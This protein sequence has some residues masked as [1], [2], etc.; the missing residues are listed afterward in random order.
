VISHVSV[1]NRP[2][3]GAYESIKF[4]CSI[5]GG[6]NADRSVCQHMVFSDNFLPD[7]LNI[8]AGGGQDGGLMRDSVVERNLIDGPIQTE[9]PGFLMRYNVASHFEIRPR[10]TDFQ[11]PRGNRIEQ[12]VCDGRLAGFSCVRVVFFGPPSLPNVYDGLQARNNLAFAPDNRQLFQADPGTS[13]SPPFFGAGNVT[14]TT[15][16][17]V[18]ANPNIRVR[19]D[20]ALRAGSTLIN[21][22]V[23]V[24]FR[25]VDLPGNPAPVGGSGCRRG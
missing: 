16:P 8:A 15:N 3:G 6:R 10:E 1:A 7:R 23:P 19:T 14:V 17:F 13:A 18:A 21:Q 12:N 4:H 11:L 9:N 5:A 24:S 20:Y 22:G 2:S 25:S